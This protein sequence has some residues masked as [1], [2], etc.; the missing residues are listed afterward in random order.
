MDKYYKIHYTVLIHSQ[1]STVAP[2]K[3]GNWYVISSHI[4]LGTL[5]IIHAAIKINHILVKGVHGI[6][7]KV[8]L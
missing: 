6:H 8:Q 5:F 2:L 7:Q 4:L 1:T 3:F